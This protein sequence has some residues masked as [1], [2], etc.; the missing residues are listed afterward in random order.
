MLKRIILL[1]ACACLLMSLPAFAAGE[2]ESEP[3]SRPWEERLAEAREKYNAETVNVYRQ[4]KGKNK[5]D[6]INVRIYLSRKKQRTFNIRESLKIDDE[7]EMQAILEVIMAEGEF[8]EASYGSVSF[9]TAQWVAHNMAYEMATGSASQKEG[10]KSLTGKS[11]SKI[12]NS[13]KE[14]DIGPVDSI[15]EDELK[16]YRMIEQFLSR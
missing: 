10:I 4:G 9:M 7:A 1:L 2:S 16:Y 11:L 6:K 3:D 8:D 13:A 12:I 14:L 5:K 15:P